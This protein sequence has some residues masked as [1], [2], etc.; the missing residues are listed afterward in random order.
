MIVHIQK[1]KNFMRNLDNPTENPSNNPSEI[2]SN[3][4][5]EIPSNNPSEVPSNNPSEI[6]SNNPSEVQSNIPSEVPSNNPNEETITP[7]EKPTAIPTEVPTTT[8]NEGTSTQVEFTNVLTESESSASSSNST[9]APLTANPNFA[10]RK[11]NVKIHILSFNSFKAR[12]RLITFAVFFLFRAPPFYKTIIFILTIRYYRRIGGFRYL[13][14]DKNETA[15]CT[16][17][18]EIIEG[19]NARYTCESSINGNSGDIEQVA[20]V[21][22]N[23]PG[24]SS[25]EEINFSDEALIA[26]SNLQNFTRE[27]NEMYDLKNGE[28]T[29]SNKYFVIEGDIDDYQGKVGNEFML[30]VYDNSSGSNGVLKNASC[31]V[32]KITNKKHQFRCTSEEGIHGYIHLASMYNDNKTA[33]NLYMN[34]NNEILSFEGS[35]NNGDVLKN[36]PI[37]RKSSSGLSGGAIAGIVIACAVALIIAS[38]IA[39]MLRKPSVPIKNNSSITEIRSI[40]NY[41]Q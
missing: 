31:S 13:Q 40:N 23:I 6:P 19:K 18:S 41:T 26:A 1:I 25:L 32:H 39:M 20:I 38:I 17:D 27:V 12:G 3:N 11:R 4:P 7:T 14:E 8:P 28:L 16:A 34:E 29:N 22:L 10:G 24:L 9:D 36:N 33:I 5:S 15:N 2:P 35:G 21:D 37:Y 30:Q